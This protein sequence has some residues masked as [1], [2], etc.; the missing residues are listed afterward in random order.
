VSTRVRWLADECVDAGLVSRLRDA[1]HD[2]SYTAEVSSGASDVDVLRQAQTETRL[3]LTEDKGF[4]E[5]VFRLKLSVPGVVLLRLDPE[6]HLLKWK[7]LEAAIARFG[8]R[9]FGRYLVIEEV[10]FRSRPLLRTIPG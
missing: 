5:L 9:L 4:G 10:R 2:V 6:K 8:E 3:L 1:G 7:R